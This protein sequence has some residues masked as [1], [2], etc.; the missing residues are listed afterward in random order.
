[1]LMDRRRRDI[2]LSVLLVLAVVL[3]PSYLVFRPFFVGFAVAGSVAILLA[4]LHLR[5]ARA[6]GGRPSLA[7]ALLVLTAT[8]AILL[9]VSTA[10]FILGNQAVEFFNWVTPQLAPAELERLFEET[11]PAR[12]PGLWALVSA[13]QENLTTL[14][15][16]GLTQLAGGASGLVQRLL[17]G[18]A[19]AAFELFLFLFMLFF[20]L[21]DG[22]KLQDEL[23]HLSP[24]SG[25]Q[26]DII[27]DNVSRTVKGVLQAMIVV[28]LVQGFLASIGFWIFGVPHPVSWGVAVTL[29]AMVPL[30]GSPLGWV[31]ACVYL[32][33]QGETWQWVGMLAFGLVVIS[34][35][36]NVVKP[37]LLKESADIHPL[38][39]FLSI[40]GG[41]L[42]FGAFGFLVGPVI[43]SSLMSA[44][45]IYK[46][47]V[48]RL[49]APGRSSATAA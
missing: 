37:L 16:G 36:D 22:E 42:A 8:A 39:G 41:V 32:F 14:V 5:L 11:L 1:M 6:L 29:A 34:G 9:P 17:T 38:L 35:I 4:P 3:I 21:K 10:L 15:G 24:L 7:A 43:L 18:V 48:I 25:E 19:S 33:L 13:R 31:P 47:H 12:Y 44:I 23:R 2:L 26:E 28:P 45:R 46:L 49:G 40:L 30:L 20:L 27:F